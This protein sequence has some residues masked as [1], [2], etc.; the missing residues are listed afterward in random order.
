MDTEARCIT[1][2]DS[3]LELACAWN[4]QRDFCSRAVY[5][6]ERA[7]TELPSLSACDSL[8]IST[9]CVRQRS[10]LSITGTGLIAT[11]AN[12]DGRS[13]CDAGNTTA[14][15]MCM[16]QVQN[17]LDIFNVPVVPTPTPYSHPRC[18]KYLPISSEYLS[19]N[20]FTPGVY[21]APESHYYVAPW[22]ST[23]IVFDAQGDKNARFIIIVGYFSIFRGSMTLIN[24]AKASNIFW[25]GQ[26]VVFQ[27]DIITQPA[28]AYGTFLLGSNSSLHYAHLNG[29]LLTN[30]VTSHQYKDV[31]I[32][33]ESTIEWSACSVSAWENVGDC[34]ATCGT[35]A[36]I[37]Q[38]RSVVMDGS[39]CPELSRNATCTG[40]PCPIDCVVSDW[41]TNNLCAGECGGKDGVM[42]WNR[43]VLVPSDHGGQSC[44]NLTQQTACTTQPCPIDCV[45]SDWSTN[46]L[47]SVECGAGGVM[48][49]N[50]SVLVP[51]DHGGQ[52]C[53]SLTQQ[54]VCN[55]H[56][57]PIDCLLSEWTCSAEC[58]DVG[59]TTNQTRAVL[60]QPQHGGDLCS[61]LLHRVVPCNGTTCITAQVASENE[62]STV[63]T[64][65]TI[66]IVSVS[67]VVAFVIALA[68]GRFVII[69]WW[70]AK[71]AL[72]NVATSSAIFDKIETTDV[73]PDVLTETNPLL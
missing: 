7:S 5:T 70:A 38:V 51:S 2:R 48:H 9:Q 60:R 56:P 67:V 42:H 47:C 40:P 24:G 20:T 43:N 68:I 57:C 72:A 13:D 31:I 1:A 52:S 10:L 25:I 35:N 12:M 22:Y 71:K 3:Y 23:N 36:T 8:A 50:R 32:S 15:N 73:R 37:A 18:E 21:C 28:R 61:S 19:A 39:R 27:S 58:G 41:S 16:Q 44:A 49:W 54:T 45:V 34:T 30:Q 4:N 26:Q 17:V 33:G 53:G 62:S 6:F 14:N 69:P 64:S 63:L 29:Q 46:N 59:T 11:T 65:T 55:T 66:V